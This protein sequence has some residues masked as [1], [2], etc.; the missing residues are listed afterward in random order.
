MSEPLVRARARVPDGRPRPPGRLLVVEL[1][2]EVSAHL[3]AALDAHLGRCENAP[4]RIPVPDALRDLRG[5]L[6]DRSGQ[7][8]PAARSAWPGDAMLSVA[9]AAARLGV[10]TRT[11]RR[12]VAAGELR[13]ARVGRLVRISEGEL[14]DYI[15]R[16]SG[17]GAA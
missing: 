8:R 7:E 15:R 4:R 17:R 10:S 12:R 14:S 16:R 13:C 2:W 3:A 5:L 11:V 9:E 6:A 1:D